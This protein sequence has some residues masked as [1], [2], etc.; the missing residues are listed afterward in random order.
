MQQQTPNSIS[1]EH[2]TAQGYRNLN[3]FSVAPML[4]GMHHN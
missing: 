4:D 2:T 3:R 1:I